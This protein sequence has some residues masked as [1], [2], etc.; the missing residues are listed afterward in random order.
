[1]SVIC[2]LLLIIGFVNSFILFEAI[3]KKV[4]FYFMYF[5]FFIIKVIRIVIYSGRFIVKKLGT[6][7]HLDLV[8][9]PLNVRT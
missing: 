5:L 6:R 1:M 8:C 9:T 3:K 2:L 4:K 7:S